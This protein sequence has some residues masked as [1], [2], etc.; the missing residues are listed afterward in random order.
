LLEGKNGNRGR[1]SK[2]YSQPGQ[3]NRGGWTI[4]KVANE[5]VKVV[6]YEERVTRSGENKY[7]TERLPH[8]SH[9]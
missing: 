3:K 1:E 6:T 2:K 4:L 5:I 9:R 8:T 7:R